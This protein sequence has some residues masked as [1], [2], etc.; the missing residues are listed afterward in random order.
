[1]GHKVLCTFCSTLLDTW[2]KGW[3]SH[4]LPRHY[5]NGQCRQI[6]FLTKLLQEMRPGFFAYDPKTKWQSSEW[7]G[8]TSPRLK[9][10]KF[11]RFCI[12]TMLIIF[13]NLKA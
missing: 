3:S 6:F 5:C 10:L 4:I 8:E 12:K 13:S 9:K 11:Q 2:A 1:L 7:V